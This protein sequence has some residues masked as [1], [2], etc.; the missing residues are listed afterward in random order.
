MMGIE[1]PPTPIIPIKAD[2]AA[3]AM[4]RVLERL[5]RLEAGQTRSDIPA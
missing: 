3:L 2:A 1:S 4:R 5:E